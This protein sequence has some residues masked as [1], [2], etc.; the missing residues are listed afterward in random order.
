MSLTH[1]GRHIRLAPDLFT[2]N[3]QT[4]REWQ[5]IF[6]VHKNMQPRMLYPARLSFRMEGD[7]VSNTKLKE[8]MKTKIVLK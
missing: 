2:D 8:F 7:I 1:K 3:W 6:N 5:E 4:K